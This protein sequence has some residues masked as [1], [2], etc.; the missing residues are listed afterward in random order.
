MMDLFVK[1]LCPMVQL[2]VQACIELN[3]VFMLPK[4]WKVWRCYK[5]IIRGNCAKNI[6]NVELFCATPIN[7]GVIIVS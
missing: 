7:I 5:R 3:K 2:T 6:R 4:I 1:F